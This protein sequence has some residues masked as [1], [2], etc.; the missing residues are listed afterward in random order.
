MKYNNLIFLSLLFACQ[1][2]K[3]AENR[4]EELQYSTPEEVGMSMDSLKAIETLVR[5]Y[6]DEKKFP[7]AVTLIAK[8]GKIVYESEVGWNDSLKTTSYRKDDIFRLASMTKPIVS[9]AA[10]QLVEKGKLNLN[11]PIS[12]YIPEFKNIEVLDKLNP[13]D[14]TWTTISANREPNIHHL[15][16]HTAGIPYGFV[17]PPVHGALLAKIEV[18]ELT[19]IADLTIE[20]ISTRLASIP[21]VHQPGERWMYGLNTDVLGRLVEVAS[22][23]NLSQYVNENILDPLGMHSTDF[24]LEDSLSGRLVEVYQNN[25]SGQF[26]YMKP[27]PPFYHPDYPIYGA[28]KHYSGGS[29]LSGT[30]RD[31]FK[32]CQA[33]LNN[34]AYN[35]VRILDAA[36]VQLMVSN[37][38]DSLS[39]GDG[40]FGYGF[41]I[42]NDHLYMADGS[43]SWGGAFS[44]TFW[45]DPINKLVVV[46]LRQVFFSP[47]SN[48]ID[49]ELKEIVYGALL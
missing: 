37:Q 38:I 14:S 23:Q 3:E 36:A 44:T 26:T 22:G 6:I 31:Y 30:A 47:Y 24:F 42:A 27:N 28:K 18:P 10:M 29:G 45:V 5:S 25:D 21:L 20:E 13:E 17:N 40:K 19:S 35:G 49:D 16:T 2:V 1:S 4:T 33:L 9:V 15:L 34:G 48:K 32:F 39:V 8:N 7:G 11:D 41:Y 46:Q 12:K 43:F